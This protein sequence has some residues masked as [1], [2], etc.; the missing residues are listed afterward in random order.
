MNHH[1][2]IKKN[3]WFSSVTRDHLQGGDINCIIPHKQRIIISII[4]LTSNMMI[5]KTLHMLKACLIHQQN[6]IIDKNI[7]ARL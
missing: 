5:L 1:D 7:Y 3:Q 4:D 2:E 6:G